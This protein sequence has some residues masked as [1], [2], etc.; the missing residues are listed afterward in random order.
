MLFVALPV[1]AESQK[2]PAQMRLNVILTIDESKATDFDRSWSIIAAQAKKDGFPFYTV[3]SESENKR[4]IL[5]I[6]SSYGDIAKISD[7][8]DRYTNGQNST[9]KKEA[10]LLQETVLTYHS[11]V[12]RIANNLTYNPPDSYRSGF[13]EYSH[14]HFESEDKEK[15]EKLFFN[16]RGMLE[17][18]GVKS[19]L[20]IRW[21]TL[22]SEGLGLE[23]L[24]AANAPEELAEFEQEITTKVDKTQRAVFEAQLKALTK[25]VT[26]RKWTPRPDLSISTR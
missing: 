7:F 20:H 6:I 9:L 1:A 5:S 17:K 16:Y 23:V 25:K 15:V 11:Y 13:V 26:Y 18:A 2:M 3:V 10:S 22:G 21:M 8:V 24:K 19:A 4:L 12:T 14:Y